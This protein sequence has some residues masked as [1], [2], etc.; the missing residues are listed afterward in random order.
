MNVYYASRV[1]CLDVAIA[2]VHSCSC[3]FVNI[4]CLAFLHFVGAFCTVSGLARK[5]IREVE[6]VC[7]QCLLIVVFI[8]DDCR[9]NELS[10]IEIRC[11]FAFARISISF[12]SIKADIDK[13]L[14]FSHCVLLGFSHKNCAHHQH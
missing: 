13:R 12:L 10:V 6:A 14:L 11:L 9:L 1:S 7:H 4:P 2:S 8:H 5:V 3:S